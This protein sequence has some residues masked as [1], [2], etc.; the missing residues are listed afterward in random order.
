ML[1]RHCMRTARLSAV[2]LLSC[3]LGPVSSAHA[4]NGLNLIGFGA[5]SVAM[6][7]ADLAVTSSPTALNIN[8]AGMPRQGQML[9][10]TLGIGLALNNYHT[11]AAGDRVSLGN[12]LSAIGS[13][14][15]TRAISNFTLGV[16]L[17]AQGGSGSMFSNIETPFGT[18][19]DLLSMIGVL[20]LTPGVAWHPSETFSVGV[21]VPINIA[22][23]KQ[24]VYPDT[25]TAIFS[26]YAIRD[27]YAFTPSVKVG[28]MV[29]LNDRLTLAAAYS[30]KTEL[31]FRNAE[32][33][34]N[35]T[36]QG[37][38]Y[39]TY[40]DTTL[41]GISLPQ[42]LGV[43]VAFRATPHLLLALDVDWLD[44]SAAVKR[45]TLKATSP[46]SA[47]APQTIESSA[48]M[49]W[50][51]QVVVALGAA[52]DVNERVTVRAGYNY[53]K[54]PVPD[55]S[56]SPLLAPIM[57]QSVTLGMGYRMDGGWKV[58]GALEW[59][60]GREVTYTSPVSLTGNPSSL[61]V[62]ILAAYLTLAKAW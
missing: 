39:V 24:D 3:I 22:A 43:G 25:S 48:E 41:E 11:D 6:G 35:F 31:K 40:D 9:D 42:Q 61:Q 13:G 50:K 47:L 7:G 53:G 26:G 28:T 36:A 19:D 2:V 55:S 16:G 17:F 10:N 60:V 62:G 30:S 20:R 57:E 58:D 59:Q 34:V 8:P 37:L 46:N 33:K 23:A 49:N 12:P 5:E 38:G 15:Y 27:A 52:Y 44:W 54:S 14:G 21:S 51:D 45:S 32:M 56:L 1:I 18:Q 4:N 29:R